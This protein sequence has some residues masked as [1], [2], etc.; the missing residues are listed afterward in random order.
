MFFSILADNFDF[1]IR[2]I[3]L[4]RYGNGNGTNAQILAMI[5]E[6]VCEHFLVGS[7]RQYYLMMEE[8]RIFGAHGLL[9]YKLSFLKTF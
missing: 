7:Y 9:Y 1:V 4:L 8:N 5:I 6:N 2:R 3:M